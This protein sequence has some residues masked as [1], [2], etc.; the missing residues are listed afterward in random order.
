MIHEIIRKEGKGNSQS[1]FGDMPKSL[2]RGM[3]KAGATLVNDNSTNINFFITGGGLD[4]KR[5]RE[6][7]TVMSMINE[8][9]PLEAGGEYVTS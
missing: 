9:D 1:L 5:G 2:S 3:E 7:R 8:R 6:H 4:A